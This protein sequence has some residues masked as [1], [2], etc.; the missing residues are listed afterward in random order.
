ML[1]QG[2]TSE[3]V[4]RYIHPVKIISFDIIL[5]DNKIGSKDNILWNKENT[6]KD[7]L[8]TEHWCRRMP[9]AAGLGGSSVLLPRLFRRLL[10][11]SCELS[12]SLSQMSRSV[13][14]PAS[15]AILSSGGVG[16]LLAWY[17]FF[18]IILSC[19]WILNSRLKNSS[20]ME[21]GLV[22]SGRVAMQN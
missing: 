22:L 20:C 5:D 11:M 3:P 18:S 12:N 9:A 6:S 10:L 21:R 15:S 17:N 16:R 1:Q 13:L 7:R 19:C 14:C 8:Q 2:A 4:G